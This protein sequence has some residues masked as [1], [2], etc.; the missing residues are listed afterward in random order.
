MPISSSFPIC[1]LDVFTSLF[2]GLGVSASKSSWNDNEVEV[3]QSFGPLMRDLFM[4]KPSAW[5]DQVDAAEFGSQPL[6]ARRGTL[7][8][9][10][11]IFKS[12]IDRASFKI[13]V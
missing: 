10:Y 12:D 9:T 7:R 1:L 5:S 3:L 2:D 6:E 8:H 4:V 11:G 13:K